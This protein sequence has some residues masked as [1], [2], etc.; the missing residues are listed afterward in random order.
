MAWYKDSRRHALSARG[1][2]SAQKCPCNL[3][4]KKD[5]RQAKIDKYEKLLKKDIK[6]PYE[7]REKIA[8][9]VTSITT[10][11]NKAEIK[12]EIK[13]QKKYQQGYNDCFVCGKWKKKGRMI[14]LDKRERGD[15]LFGREFVCDACDREMR[16]YNE[17]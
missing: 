4:P 6:F 14:A 8:E 16:N 5:F 7:I 10:F 13:R 11:S 9:G 15:G 1:I 2:K 3:M 12:K 17:F